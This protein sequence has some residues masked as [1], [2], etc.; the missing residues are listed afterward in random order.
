MVGT[1][2]MTTIMIGIGVAD[3][4]QIFSRAYNRKRKWKI[5]IILSLFGILFT[6]ASL[7]TSFTWGQVTMTLWGLS[8]AA[9]VI[10]NYVNS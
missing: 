4:M 5:I 1:I 10:G 2:V 6:Q 9:G 8:L 7:G 3:V